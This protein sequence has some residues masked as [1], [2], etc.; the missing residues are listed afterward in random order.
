MKMSKAFPKGFL[1]GGA[2]SAPQHEGGFSEGGKGPT[3]MDYI[4]RF[5]KADDVHD[6]AVCLTPEKYEYNK[7]HEDI[8]NLPFRRGTDFYHRYKEDIALMGEMGFKSF[9]MSI[10][11]AR[12]FPTG[13][14]KEPCKEGVEFYHNV[15]KE[16]KK[17]NIEPLITMIHYDIPAYLTETLNGWESPKTI[18]YF[19]NYTKFIIDEYKGE[20][21]H[22]LT[23]N[24][25]NMVMW[26]SYLGGGMFVEKSDLDQESCIHQAL[27]HQLIASALTVKYLHDTAP[28]CI[29]GN[30][31]ARLQNYPYTCKPEDCYATQQQNKFNYFPVDI[32]AKGQYPKFIL[33][34]YEQHNIRFNW[35][36]NYEKI[37]SEGT[38]DFLSISYYH[39]GVISDDE[40]KREPIGRFVREL[41][42]PY[43]KATAWGWNI[44]PIGL[45]ISLNEMYDRYGLPIY[46]VENGVAARESLTEDNK[47]HDQYR[48]EYLKAHIQAIKGAID[49]GVEVMGYTPWGC[50]DI[51]SCGDAQMSK[52]YGFVYVDADDYGN[53]TYNRYRK[54]SFYWYK[55]VIAT[56]GEDLSID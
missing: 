14:E 25:I 6:Y 47:V 46:V 7:T 4:A 45:R 43:L 3:H 27:H 42:N 26:F 40:D 22:W 18:D 30:M 17:Y 36:P 54:D 19:M 1:W 44:D 41:K 51:V 48:C 23:F 50:I 2:T 11:W 37:L 20:V 39:T 8:Q 5:D 35:Y 55:K 29:V 53:G 28:G 13:T 49:D 21:K 9:R 10:C 52:H 56:N 38:V 16:L 12:L 33:N 34:Y 31:L 15:F 32:Q 24:E